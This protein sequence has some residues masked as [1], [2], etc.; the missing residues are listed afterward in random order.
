[1][2]TRMYFPNRS[3]AMALQCKPDVLGEGDSSG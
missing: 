1:L 3:I 2:S